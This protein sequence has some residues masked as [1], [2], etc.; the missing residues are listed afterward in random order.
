M[1][2]S[3]ET[4]VAKLHGHMR[5]AEVDHPY[6]VRSG[7]KSTFLRQ[8]LVFPLQIFQH[9]RP[10]YSFRVRLMVISDKA[11]AGLE[12][13]IGQPRPI[14]RGIPPGIQAQNQQAP[15][16]NNFY[17]RADDV[18]QLGNKEQATVRIRRQTRL[19]KL[20][21]GFFIYSAHYATPSRLS[22]LSSSAGFFGG[23]F[24]AAFLDVSAFLS[25]VL[26][27]AVLPPLLLEVLPPI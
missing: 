14:A 3:E 26:P 19:Q 12:Y 7:I 25:P 9:G 4:S 18:L 21:A 6:F 22:W 15:V 10:P 17:S 16:A 8:K 2:N 24:A 11:V 1:R 27:L 5:L 13:G 20:A 23:S